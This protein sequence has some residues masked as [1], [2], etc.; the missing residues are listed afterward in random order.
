MSN[1]DYQRGFNAAED[2]ARQKQHVADARAFADAYLDAVVANHQANAYQQLL[3][4]YNQLVSEYNALRRDRNSWRDYAQG[5]K[6]ASEHGD[7]A[8]EAAKKG[9]EIAEFQI[10]NLRKGFKATSIGMYEEGLMRQFLADMIDVPRMREGSEEQRKRFA[11]IQEYI[12]LLREESKNNGL[13][14]DDFYYNDAVRYVS[15]IGRKI[16]D[17]ALLRNFWDDELKLLQIGP[18]TPQLR[19]AVQQRLWWRQYWL[20]RANNS[21]PM[22]S[23]TDRP[24]ALRKTMLEH[25]AITDGMLALRFAELFQR[26]LMLQFFYAL[27]QHLVRGEEAGYREPVGWGAQQKQ[28]WSPYEDALQLSLGALPFA[29][30]PAGMQQRFVAYARELTKGYPEQIATFLSAMDELYDRRMGIHPDS[31][32]MAADP[33]PESPNVEGQRQ[34]VNGGAVGWGQPTHHP[35]HQP[36]PPGA[37]VAPLGGCAPQDCAPQEGCTPQGGCAPQENRPLQGTP[38]GMQGG[39]GAAPQQG[40]ATSWG[41]PPATSESK[42]TPPDRPWGGPK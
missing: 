7:R 18:D 33:F 37:T 1:A 20:D 35:A 32:P 17:N 11:R 21:F 9:R 10:A 5:L 2:S 22:V 42:P 3:A 30:F 39:W 36:P 40:P 41:Q 16:A 26:N 15:K 12:T 27:Q 28:A 24:E 25:M 8:L 14:P 19:E 31:P 34:V 38:Q 6:E 29:V 23:W 13:Q 4:Q